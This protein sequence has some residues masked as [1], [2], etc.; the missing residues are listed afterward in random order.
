MDYW[1]EAYLR[2]Q[3]IEIGRAMYDR[4]YIA[5]TDG[6][7][8]VKLDNGELL[9]TPSGV[10]KGRMRPEQIVRTDGEG[11]VLSEG[12]PST[13]ILM[14]IEVYRARSDARAVVHAHPPYATAFSISGISLARCVLPEIVVQMGTIPTAPYAAPSTTELPA[15]IREYL[16]YCDALILERH[17]TLTLGETLNDAY[18]KLEKVEHTA[19][20]TFIAHQL[21]GVNPLS[22]EQVEQ[23]ME[24]RRKLGITSRNTLLCENCSMMGTC[25]L[26][27]SRLQ[28]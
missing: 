6:N 17:G 19:Q 5:A 20:I 14:H 28:P 1:N 25:H 21:G 24:I 22:Q 3:M 15:T 12:T 26:D 13:E 4:G 9:M 23:L 18:H 16:G 10:P 7:I 2:T 8:S 11:R 27:L